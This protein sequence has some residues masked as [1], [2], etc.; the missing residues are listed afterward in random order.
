MREILG[1]APVEPDGSV[2][3]KVPANVPFA[4][5]VLD[6]D[7]RRIS[8]AT[9][10]GCRC[11]PGEELR[12]NGCHDPRQR[13]CR[14][15]APDLFAAAYGGATPTGLPFPNTDPALLRRLRRDHGADARAHQLPDRLRGAAADASTSSFED[16]WTDPVAAGRARRTRASPTAMRTS[17]TPAPDQRRLPDDVARAAAAITIHYEAHIH[18]LWSKP[19]ITLGGRRRHRARRRHLHELPLPTVTRRAQPQVPAGQLDLTDGRRRDAAAS[20][21]YRELL[22]ATT[23]R[24]WSAGTCRT[25]SCRSAS[26]RSRR[27]TVR[28]RA[29]Q[30]HVGRHARGSVR[31][32]AMF[33]PGGTHAGPPDPC[34]I[35]ARLRM[36]RHRGAIL[37]RPIRRAARLAE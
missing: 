17:T 1:Y 34:R 31:F 28:A 18:P 12:C 36:G 22:R 29:V 6:A 19:R 32:F 7:G 33:A 5:I 27:S 8:R 2:R 9:R 11:A 13:A 14:T 30:L 10:T 4:I 26:I 20:S 25:D 16:V 24:N 35:E 3:V 15:A 23:S 21:A 37:Q